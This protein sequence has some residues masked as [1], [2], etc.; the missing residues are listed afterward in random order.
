MSANLK[1]KI[2][3]W[4]NPITKEW[5][6]GLPE[7]YPAPNGFDKVVC[8]TAHEAELCSE[9]MRMWESFN[10]EMEDAQREMMEGPI[11]KA[12]RDQILWQAT[13]ARN[14]INRDFLLRHLEQYDKRQNRT[15]MKKVSYL[16]SEAYEEK[17]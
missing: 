2:V 7:Q 6:M 4:F 12:L 3:Y 5:R 11:R 13:N 10:G 8:N 17:N 1:K 16:H 9:K 15:Q 14:A